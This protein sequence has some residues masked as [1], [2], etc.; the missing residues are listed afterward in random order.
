MNDENIV[1]DTVKDVMS[2]LRQK[3]DQYNLDKNMLIEDKAILL[4]EIKSALI[5]L[6]GVNKS[7]STVSKRGRITNCLCNQQLIYL[8]MKSISQN[9]ELETQY[10]D[11]QDICHYS[12]PEL[13]Y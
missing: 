3:A 13:K 11:L 8:A 1:V 9:E 4:A 7:A 5:A 2:D 6:R 12:I 10:N